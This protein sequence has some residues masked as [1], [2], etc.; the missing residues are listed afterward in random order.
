M[1]QARP[2]P[3]AVDVVVIGGGMTGLAAADSLL[4][5]GL[6]V[7]LVE[8]AAEVGGLARSISVGGEGV[9]AYYHHVFPQDRELRELID[10]LGPAG[11]FEWRRASTAVLAGGRLY[12][13]DSVLDLLRFGPLSFP[14]RLRLGLGSAVALVLGRGARLQKTRVGEAGPRWF[15]RSGYAVL[16]RPLL[17]GKFGPFAP[18]VALAWLVGRMKQRANAR[19]RGTGDRL[20]YLRGG[21]GALATRYAQE[22]AARRLSLAT[23]AP[24]E[25]LT[26]DGD[27]WRVRFGG[28]EVTARAVVACLSGEALDGIA[29][30][31]E[32]YRGTL[33]S[34]PYRGV[35]CALLELDRPLGRNYWVNLIERSELGCLAVI[36]HTNFIPAD[37]Y[38]GRHLVYLTHYVEVD[39]RAWNATVDE[40]VGAAEGMLTAINAAFDRSWIRA[41][42]VSRDR[43]AQPVPLAGGP[44]PGL[45]LET[46]LPGLFHAS[47]AHIYPDDRGVSLA[48]KLGRRAGL[49]ALDWLGEEASRVPASADN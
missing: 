10:R 7:L 47:L 36:E 40:I 18:N 44:M 37:R 24:V 26:R 15:G 21:L 11:A 8:A 41:A 46:G 20:G 3:E 4:A 29:Q 28:R 34:I 30:L 25:T 13:F 6:E 27:V 39:G 49:A 33:R 5:G 23:G 1:P 16:W 48:L 45:P 31:P 22:L 42:H 19:K 2:E 14:G 17:D 12:P 38:G 32:P 9:E 43:W 35:V